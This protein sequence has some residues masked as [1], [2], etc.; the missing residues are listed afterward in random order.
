MQGL[1]KIGYT[2]KSLEARVA[3]LSNATGIPT[4]FAV[5]AFFKVDGPEALETR[6]HKVLESHRVRRQREF[7][8]MEKAEAI[9]IVREICHAPALRNS[10]VAPKRSP[11]YRDPRWLTPEKQEF[12]AIRKDLWNGRKEAFE[13]RLLTD[14]NSRKPPPVRFRDKMRKF[15]TVNEHDFRGVSR[16][17]L[18]ACHHVLAA[19]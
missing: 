2:T 10:K 11:N 1:L 8:K 13:K 16:D 14:P 18:N 9:K 19:T 15:F 4:A 17:R 3:E 6:I 5:E 12:N 7:F